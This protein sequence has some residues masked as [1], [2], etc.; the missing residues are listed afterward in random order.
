MSSHLATIHVLEV[1][2]KIQSYFSV[3]PELLESMK[4]WIQMR[5]EE[6]GSF[7]PLS[8]DVKISMFTTDI[9]IDSNNIKRS[10][11]AYEEL[12]YGIVEKWKNLSKDILQLERNV[13]TTAETLIA[14]MEIGMENDVSAYLHFMNI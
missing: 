11:N 10:L 5:Q 6:D 13:E 12:D 14:L 4:H 2:T 9:E 8:A 3:D 1:L 7:T